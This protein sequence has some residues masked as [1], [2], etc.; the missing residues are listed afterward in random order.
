MKEK[1]KEQ[2]ETIK[3]LKLEKQNSIKKVVDGLEKERREE[4]DKLNRLEELLR[5][6]KKDP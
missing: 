5:L 2:E 3:K 1:V 6:A 4:E